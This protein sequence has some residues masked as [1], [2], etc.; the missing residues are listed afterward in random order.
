MMPFNFSFR[1]LLKK[2]IPRLSKEKLDQHENIFAQ[3]AQLQIE[4]R[5]KMI[6]IPFLEKPDYYLNTIRER[7]KDYTGEAEKILLPYKNSYNAAHKLWIARREFALEQGYLLQIPPTFQR[8]VR[9]SRKAVKYQFVR[10]ETLPIL[11]VYKIIYYL[12]LLFK[13]KLEENVKND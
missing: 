4:K 2:Y 12:Q 11:W 10:I 13:Q 8:F 5:Y 9:F 3:R 6:P 7:V 1:N